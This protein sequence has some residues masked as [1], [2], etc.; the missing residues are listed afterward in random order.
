ME[1]DEAP[2]PGAY[3]QVERSSVQKDIIFAKT[4]ELIVGLYGTLPVEV[5][6]ALR[7]TGAHHYNRPASQFTLLVIYRF[8]GG[9]VY[10]IRRHHLGVHACRVR[11]DVFPLVPC[12]T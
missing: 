8:S 5:K 4:E 10:G 12:H 9:L 7:S 2:T 3:P 6:Q 11:K 1:V